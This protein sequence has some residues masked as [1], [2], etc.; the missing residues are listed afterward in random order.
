MGKWLEG[1]AVD[2][3]KIDD[4]IHRLRDNID[5]VLT[6]RHQSSRVDVTTRFFLIGK[7]WGIAV[8]RHDYTGIKGKCRFAAVADGRE[9]II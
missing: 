7:L 4:T 2:I 5:L 3:I 9:L 8:G 1:L 6:N